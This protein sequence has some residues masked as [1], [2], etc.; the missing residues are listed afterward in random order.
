MLARLVFLRRGS[1]RLRYVRRRANKNR[2]IGASLSWAPGE[3]RGFVG[4]D[5][6][7]CIS[8]KRLA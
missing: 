5:Y 7:F 1:A 2:A 3:Q 4:S 8:G 6:L